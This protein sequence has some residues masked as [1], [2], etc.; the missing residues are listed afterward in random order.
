MMTTC[1]SRSFPTVL[2]AASNQFRADVLR[3]LRA[4]RKHLPSKYFYDAA[5]SELFE[6]IT[7]LT[8]YYPTRTERA[9]MERHAAE[10]ADVIG[11]RCLLVE[12]GSGSSAKTR[13]LLD[14]LRDPAGYVPIDVSSDQLRSAA[15][16]VALD[17]PAVEV[18]PLYGDFTRPL[19]L[20]VPRRPAVRRVV[21]FPGST[22]GN[23]TP[24]EAIALLRRT[25]QLCGPN[26]AMLL[27]ADLRKDRRLLEAAY[28]DTQGVTAA[29]NRNILAR[30]NRQLGAD[31]AL[32]QFG[33]HAFFNA[34]E[35]R[36]EMHLVSRRQQRVHIDGEEF[37]FAAGESIHT[38]NSYKFTL[39]ELRELAAA[40][41]FETQRVWTDDA[42]Y[43]SVHYLTIRSA[44]IAPS[45]GPV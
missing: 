26:G 41:G 33:H 14:H 11:P 27:G 3:G 29:F 25:A 37:D 6:R 31:F 34:A 36:I 43:F 12:Y 42:H 4:P 23:F 38:E 21:Y 10:M 32:G 24:S 1:S 15:R 2:P 20:P 13:L 7:E 18:L 30:I 19:T 40:G 44:A 9:I 28:N 16:A 35:G 39:S 17:Y 5:G 45:V 22:I 8:E